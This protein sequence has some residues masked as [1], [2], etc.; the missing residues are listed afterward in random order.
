ME[1][2]HSSSA[3]L[4]CISSGTL[5]IRPLSPLGHLRPMVSSLLESYRLFYFP[6]VI[7]GKSFLGVTDF[8]AVIH[9]KSKGKLYKLQKIY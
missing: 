8:S 6:L 7:A 5:P 1:K 4:D 3:T 2:L 9:A